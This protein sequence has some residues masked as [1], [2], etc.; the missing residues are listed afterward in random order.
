MEMYDIST[1]SFDV[2]HYL[3][4]NVF[5]P[6]K[7]C[8]WPFSGCFEFTIKDRFFDEIY[9][10]HVNNAILFILLISFSTLVMILF[11][12]LIRVYVYLTNASL[13]NFLSSCFFHFRVGYFLTIPVRL[14]SYSKLTE[15]LAISCFNLL[16]LLF[17]Y[18]TFL[19]LFL[20]FFSHSYFSLYSSIVLL[21]VVC[22][23]FGRVFHLFWYNIL[24]WFCTFRLSHNA[25][26]LVS[27]SLE[28]ANDM[29]KIIWIISLY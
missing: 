2:I 1:R 19:S 8:R 7:K 6:L 28:N 13:F 12:L 26:C 29:K 24:I 22:I 27:E 16:L 23:I 21:N 15:F 17:T 3:I 4:E 14:I 10:E 18:F 9:Y 11:R 25:L 5:D 20:S